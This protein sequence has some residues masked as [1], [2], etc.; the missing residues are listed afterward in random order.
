VDPATGR[1]Q[2]HRGAS[3]I[4]TQSLGRLVAEAARPSRAS[5]R[6]EGLDYAQVMGC[7]QGHR[8]APKAST[9]TAAIASAA[10]PARR[11][12]SRASRRPEGLDDHVT[13][14]LDL[15]ARGTIKGIEAPRRSRLVRAH[16]LPQCADTI[17]GIETPTR[18]R[19]SC[20]RSSATTLTRQWILSR[21]HQGHRGAP[22]V[23][24]ASSVRKGIE[25]QRTSRRP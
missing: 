11:T 23:S 2:G 12:P 18:S 5:G 21:I 14:A 4:S 25:A 1:H 16:L 9:R 3:K 22:K 7:H 6:P 8:G 19:L 24:T 15:L 17:K 10:A 20:E 13:R